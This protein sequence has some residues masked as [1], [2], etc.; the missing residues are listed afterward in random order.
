MKNAIR[1]NFDESPSAYDRYE[2]Q[3]GRFGEL[4]DR[5]YEGMDARRTEPIETVLDAGA[6]TGSSSRQIE[7]H[8][9]ASVALDISRG[10]LR[11]NP[12]ENRVQG[13]FDHLPFE[14]ECFDAVAFTASLF[15]APDPERAAREA[16]RVRCPGAPVGAVAPLGWTT[17]D[18]EDIFTLLD[19]DSRSPTSTEAV[20]DALRNCFDVETG[21][22][23]F[24]TGGEALRTFHEIPAMSA[25][26]YPRLE[27]TERIER[28]Q[29]L[30][31]DIEGPLQQ[32]WRWFV[33]T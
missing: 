16:H 18:G 19:R 1:T 12:V 22:W 2:R 28:A 11:K 33:G 14:T 15:L 10:M 26:L 17:P 30:L 5:L 7:A 3:T 23:S 24:E 32:H 13:D 20:G 29:E 8:S 31:S 27:T 4:A 6:G 9:V 25:R 21:T